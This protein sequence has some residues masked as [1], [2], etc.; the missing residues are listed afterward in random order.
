MKYTILLLFGRFCA[1]GSLLSIFRNVNAFRHRQLL[2]GAGKGLGP[3]V[4]ML[5]CLL[6]KGRGRE[7]RENEEEKYRRGRKVVPWKG[8][9]TD[10]GT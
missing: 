5:H 6:S 10:T 8:I 3:K 2:D 9:D 7:R 4:G 1:L